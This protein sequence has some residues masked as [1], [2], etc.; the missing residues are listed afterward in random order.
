MD[1]YMNNDYTG[2]EEDLSEY[3]EKV[4]EIPFTRSNGVTKVK[5]TINELPLQFVFDTGASTVSISSVEATFMYKNDYLTAKDFVGKTQFV[6]ANGDISIGTI[7]NL[8]KV[9]FGGLELENVRASV[10]ANDAAPLLLGQSILSRLG[11]VEIDNEHNVLK[12]T[13]KEIEK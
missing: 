1:E 12:I 11:K 6:D 10:V 13:T 2:Q 9:S 8:R 7:I 4:V 5:C 3:I